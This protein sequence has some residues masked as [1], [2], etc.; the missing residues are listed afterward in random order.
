[1]AYYRKVGYQEMIG[2]IRTA[3]SPCIKKQHI[4][5]R[6]VAWAETLVTRINNPP[7]IPTNYEEFMECLGWLSKTQESGQMEL[8]V[9]RAMKYVRAS[10][11]LF[12]GT[13]E[14]SG[15]EA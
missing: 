6:D 4:H 13:E 11:H 10:Q 9:H 3:Q 14:D 12:K 15:E 5:P 1:M 2:K 8:G 7:K